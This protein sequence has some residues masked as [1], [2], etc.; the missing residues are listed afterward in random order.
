MCP[1]VNIKEKTKKKSYK[2]NLKLFFSKK[3]FI[4]YIYINCPLCQIYSKYIQ[5]NQY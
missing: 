2:D 3:N 1:A 5:K 4:I